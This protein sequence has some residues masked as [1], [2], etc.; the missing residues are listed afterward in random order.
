M[1]SVHVSVTTKKKS[2][3]QNRVQNVGEIEK[4]KQKQKTDNFLIHVLHIDFKTE[5]TYYVFVALQDVTTENGPTILIP[6]TASDELYK[7]FMNDEKIGETI[8]KPKCIA[9]TKKGDGYIFETN[10]L[11]GGLE[12]VTEKRRIMFGSKFYY[13]PKNKIEVPWCE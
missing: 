3:S 1:S 9:T 6:G 13:K 5:N 12:N 4:E 11:H 2:K 10:I 8:N 7:K